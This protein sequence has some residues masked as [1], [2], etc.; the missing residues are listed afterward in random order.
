MCSDN[1]SYESAMSNVA[2]GA[3]WLTVAPN[4][5]PNSA[6]GD[7]MVASIRSVDTSFTVGVEGASA[8]LVDTKEAIFSKLPLAAAIIAIVTFVLLFLLFGSVLLPVKAI[9]LNL[10]SLTA[11]FGAMVRIFQEGNLSG[12]LGFTAN[13]QL[14][15]S[16]SILMFC[17]AFGLSMDYEVFLLSRIKEEHDAG[18][19]NTQA[20]AIGLERTGS[21]V[22]AAAALLAI[23]FL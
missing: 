9:V 22:T 20:V 15:V 18:T 5:P 17:I 16:M 6:A 8:Q 10:L 2:D 12:L 13:G 23:T 11:T 14:D 21:I 19:P 7:A 3:T 1:S 4:I